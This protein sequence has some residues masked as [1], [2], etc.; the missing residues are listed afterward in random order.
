MTCQVFSASHIRTLYGKSVVATMN[1][2][3]E[4][5][6]E[7]FFAVVN[8]EGQHALWQAGL[9]VPPGWRRGSAVMSRSECLAAIADSWPDVTPASARAGAAARSADGG[10]FVHE[11]FAQ[12]AG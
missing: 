7:T 3:G 2:P 10:P 5:A 6:P 1:R 12:Q 8:D 9:D 11:L 4:A